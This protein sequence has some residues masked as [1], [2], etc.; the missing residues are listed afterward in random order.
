MKKISAIIVNWNTKEFLRVCL[1]GLTQQQN[2][3]LAIIVVDNNSADGSQDMVRNEFPHVHLITNTTNKGF[4]FANNQALQFAHGDYLMLINPDIEFTNQ[5]TL[6]LIIEEHKKNNAAIVGPQLRNSDGS[7]QAS[8]R[9]NPDWFSQFLIISKLQYIFK[10]NRT[11]K[12]YLQKD[13]DYSQ[14]A[15]VEQ[16]S[17]AFFSISRKCLNVT[18]LLDQSFWIWFEEVDYCIR[19]TYQQQHIWYTACTSVI[20]HG[21]QCFIQVIPKERH[22]RYTQSLLLYAGKYFPKWQRVLLRV[23]AMIGFLIS[24]IT[25]KSKSIRAYEH[26]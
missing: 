3:Q 9:K 16:I 23:G 1:R 18:G 15:F 6:S 10:K 13:F 21:G 26:Q 14:S 4:A 11:L 7:L 19:A 25:P 17:G 20:H 5:H 12:N 22:K 2:V 24:Y 8:V